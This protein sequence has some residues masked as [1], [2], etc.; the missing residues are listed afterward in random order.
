M[1]QV[2]NCCS[3]STL[4]TYFYYQNDDPISSLYTHR[5]STRLY[6]KP[7]QGNLFTDNI[8]HK[9]HTPYGGTGDQILLP[10]RNS[11]LAV[12]VEAN[13][14]SAMDVLFKYSRV[15]IRRGVRN[16]SHGSP[17]AS[18]IGPNKSHGCLGLYSRC[19][20][21]LTNLYLKVLQFD[22]LIQL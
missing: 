6:Q 1:L 10:R 16:I 11:G 19:R 12:L 21:M 7:P 9:I 13:K 5:R 15:P 2:E 3:K 18:F 20:F 4:D 17:F 22:I 8:F 14:I